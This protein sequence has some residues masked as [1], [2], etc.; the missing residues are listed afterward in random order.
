[1]VLPDPN[2][3]PHVTRRY[4]ALPVINV[5]AV[6]S[7]AQPGIALASPA[8]AH[9]ILGHPAR[10]VQPGPNRSPLSPSVLTYRW[11]IALPLVDIFT[12]GRYT[13]RPPE[14]IGAPAAPAEQITL[15]GDPAR[16]KVTARHLN[17]FDCT[18]S[19]DRV[20]LRD[21]IGVQELSILILV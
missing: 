9:A 6:P 2:L 4:I 12:P 16:V 3:R 1:V 7:R 18:L 8:H 19:G 14:Q 11:H 20:N 10:M 5:R 17:P 21:D 15:L 13:K